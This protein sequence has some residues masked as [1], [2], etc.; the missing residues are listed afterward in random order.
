MVSIDHTSRI[1]IQ[2]R[3]H[4][5]AHPLLARLSGLRDLRV[6]SLCRIGLTQNV[7]TQCLYDMQRQ[8]L[9]SDDGIVG[10]PPFGI[11]DDIYAIHVILSSRC[12]AFKMLPPIYDLILIIK[13]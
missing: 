3:R 8:T 12:R 4:T 1:D 10:Q 11:V 5:N 2:R 6:L 9:A 13:P 7:R